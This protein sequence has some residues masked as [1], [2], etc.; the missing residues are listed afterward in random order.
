MADI[1]IEI[2]YSRNFDGVQI[3]VGQQVAQNLTMHKH[4]PGNGLFQ[5]R[6][7]MSKRICL[8][9]L[10]FLATSCGRKVQP[11]AVVPTPFVSGPAVHEIAYREGLKAFRLATP[12][13]YQRAADLFGK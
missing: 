1:L 9:L 10:L 3:T 8:G 2:S 6:T 7:Y 4:P 11:K 5:F 12:E 13:G